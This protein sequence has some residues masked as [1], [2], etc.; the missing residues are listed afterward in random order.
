MTY[1]PEKWLRSKILRPGQTQGRLSKSYG[2]VTFR[3]RA[4][5]QAADVIFAFRQPGASLNE[6]RFHCITTGLL[7]VKWL[8][9]HR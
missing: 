5:S 8:T 7:F 1:A 3:F 6:S 2:L 4:Y 9:E